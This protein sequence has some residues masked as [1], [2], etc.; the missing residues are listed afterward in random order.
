[1]QQK[2]SSHRSASLVRSLWWGGLLIL[3]GTWSLA[4]SPGLASVKP[5]LTPVYFE[6]QEEA[7][8]VQ[9]G[10][11][12]VAPFEEYVDSLQP[13]FTLTEQAAF[14]TAIAQSQIEDLR[15]MRALLARIAVALPSTTTSVQ[16]V[17]T[18]SNGTEESSRTETTQETPPTAPA[19]NAPT[20]D[21]TLG[22]VPTAPSGNV[23]IDAALRYRAA[24]ALFQDVALLS[25]YVREAAVGPKTTPFIVRLLVTVLPSARTAPYDA[26]ATV[27]FFLD[28]EGSPVSYLV[29]KEPDWSGVKDTEIQC[30]GAEVQVIPLFVTDNLESTATSLAR[31][32]VRG[33]DASAGGVVSNVGIGAGVASK[34]D[35]SLGTRGIDLSGIQTLA[36]TSRN[37][38]QVRLGAASSQGGYRAVPRTY[39]LTALILVPSK[40]VKIPTN[41]PVRVLACESLRYFA[42]ASFRETEGG[43]LL[44][45]GAKADL[46]Q[47]LDSLLRNE[48]DLNETVNLDDAVQAA[49]QLNY[50]KFSEALLKL[51]PS[52]QTAVVPAVWPT[53]ANLMSSRGISRGS[54]PLP[55]SVFRFFA[56][57]DV[58]DPK[59]PILGDGKTARITLYGNAQ[60]L[61]AKFLSGKLSIDYNGTPIHLDSSEAKVTADRRG[62]TVT[63]PSVKAFLDKIVATTPAALPKSATITLDYE[64]TLQR[65]S[66]EDDQITWNWKQDGCPIILTKEEE[67]AKSAPEFELRSTADFIR[68][69]KDGT[70][71]LALEIKKTGKV[72]HKVYF[73]VSGGMLASVIPDAPF[74][75]A[76]RAGVA[77]NAYVLS[78]K[79]LIPGRTVIVSS[80]RMDGD[81]VV[82]APDVSL[83]VVPEPETSAAG[84]PPQEGRPTTP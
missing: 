47:S 14:E 81:T 59:V 75:G 11:Q 39:N 2:R 7:G 83:F 38:I 42:Q 13:R 21:T 6:S 45:V 17:L 16:E 56:V 79:S 48:L 77:D 4:C 24:A 64:P 54:F 55:K 3:M 34:A 29:E 35:A 61:D 46:T 69:R 80:W 71:E 65:W 62:A 49:R 44:P 76:Y 25:S 52:S 26:Y 43:A 20:I 10:V 36:V 72:A 41:R 60:R 63:F 23:A 70:G 18:R 84:R 73:R 27:S 12:S 78:L 50:K 1:M 22:G 33:I 51:T 57:P 31:E 74:A 40:T 30:N 67:K 58:K 28:S 15:E 53:V 68:A 82:N 19:A 66:T 9:V 32:S 5:S 8:S 37:T